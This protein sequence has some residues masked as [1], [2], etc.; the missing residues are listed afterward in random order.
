LDASIDRAKQLK[1]KILNNNI[2]YGF[3][4]YLAILHPF[5]RSVRSYLKKIGGP[6]SLEIK[7][8]EDTEIPSEKADTF[9]EGM[10]F[11]LFP[12]VLAVSAAVIER[13]LAPTEAILQTVDVK[14]KAL[15]KYKG[16]PISRE[17]FA[18]I[19]FLVGNKRVT[20][21]VGKGIGE[22]PDKQMII[23][24]THGRNIKIDFR[25]DSFS[26]NDKPEGNL[27]SKHV[28]SFLEAVLKGDS[29][30]SAPGVLSFSA[31]FAIL[32]RLSGIRGNINMGPDYDIGTFPP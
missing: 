11:D 16:Y 21:V 23:Y 24:G 32:E 27:R 6:E 2:V 4:H 12:H 3:D 18:R 29:I 10:I 13:K 31:A 7:I 30:D 19:E 15:A 8:L 28:E 22:T 1:A 20:G 17:T 9:R 14:E 5:L 25:N 26:V